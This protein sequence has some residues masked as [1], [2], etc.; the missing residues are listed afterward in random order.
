MESR[1]FHTE[2][3]QC[4][5]LAATAS[6]DAPQPDAACLSRIAELTGFRN[7][8]ST[9]ADPL[10]VN[11]KT[12]GH[13]G[14]ALVAPEETIASFEVARQSGASWVECDASATRDLDLVCRHGT[15]DLAT[16]TDIVANHP[17]ST[18][19]VYRCL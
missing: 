15:C 16:T 18:Q 7:A 11:D 14:A 10:A 1:L 13:R 2:P 4:P 8:L 17:A 19:S 12:I 9:C 3:I 5:W 6:G